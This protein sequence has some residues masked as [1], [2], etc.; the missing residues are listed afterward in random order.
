MSPDFQSLCHTNNQYLR[1]F[2]QD[3][4]DD[5]T[6]P[7]KEQLTTESISGDELSAGAHVD[8]LRF[9]CKCFESNIFIGDDL[10]AD[11]F[12]GVAQVCTGDADEEGNWVANIAHKQ[13]QGQIGLAVLGDVEIASNSSTSA[14]CHGWGRTQ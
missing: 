2:L 3:F 12:P 7:L 9:R 6:S 4:A 5:Y 11:Q 1:L 10:E 8:I 14:P 13:L